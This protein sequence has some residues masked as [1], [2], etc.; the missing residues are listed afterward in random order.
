MLKNRL[1][2]VLFL[3][4]GFLVRSES[5]CIHQNLGNPFSQVERYNAWNVDELIYIDISESSAYTKK[6]TDLGKNNHSP[7]NTL[8]LIKMVS[9]RCFMPLTFGGGIRELEEIRQ[10]F[11]LGADKITLNSKA[12]DDPEFIT[13][14]A[15]RFGSQA[16]VIS[17]D[18]KQHQNG[19]YE[20][21]SGRGKHATG[22]TPDTWAQEAEKRGAGEILLNS[23]DLDGRATGYDIDLIR[24]VVD[25]TKIPVIA[26]GGASGHQDFAQAVTAGGSAAA[27]AGNLFHFKELAY[28]M[29]K[30]QL[31]MAG[32]NFR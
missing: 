5:F 4:D 28:P 25:A 2:P 1:I 17:I 15:K 11:S 14:A 30:R 13:S 32:L 8:E 22:W 19:Q 3:K 16:I 21:F 31:K 10:R 6:R 29:A 20:V 26:C 18:V 27:A 9:S 23:I 7:A 24:I 12:L